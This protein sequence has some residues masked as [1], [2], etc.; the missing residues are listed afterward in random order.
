MVSQWQ[1]PHKGWCTLN[2]N[3]SMVAST[4]FA[5]CGRVLQNH[6]G[7][8]L[9]GFFRKVGVYSVLEAE[10]WGVAEGLRLAWD[11]GIQ[12]MLFEVDN[13]NVARIVQD[14]ARVSGLHE[15]VPTISELVGRDWVVRVRQIRRSANMVADGMA[16][17][18]RS[19]YVSS[20][21]DNGLATQVFSMPRDEVVTLVLD[22]VSPVLG[23]V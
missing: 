12:V 20:L 2:T 14:K 10:L 1:V 7:D 18:V 23:V 5:T 19:F 11:V 22:D 17:L 16:N 6:V 8:W 13:G 21:L 15:L 4:G 9:L 3:G